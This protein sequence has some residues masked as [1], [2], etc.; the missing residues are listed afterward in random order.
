MTPIRASFA[1]RLPLKAKN[2]NAFR[3]G[4]KM[5]NQTEGILKQ[6]NLNFGN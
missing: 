1:N 3:N 6:Q 2:T 4:K 5:E